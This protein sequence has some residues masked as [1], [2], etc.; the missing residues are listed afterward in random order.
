M[1]FMVPLGLSGVNSKAQ[2]LQLRTY[3]LNI[4]ITNKQGLASDHDLNEI[5]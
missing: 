1:L 5:V 4:Y 3:N 2:P